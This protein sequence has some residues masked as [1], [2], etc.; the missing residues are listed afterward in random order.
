MNNIYMMGYIQFADG[1]NPWVYFNDK[2]LYQWIPR[3][4]LVADP[5]ET[6]SFTAY[7]RPKRLKGYE[8]MKNAIR[9]LAIEWQGAFDERR[10]AYGDLATWRGFFTRYGT[11]YGLMR[12]FHENGIC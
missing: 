1:S 4:E 6:D 11:R 2:G 3:F 8:Q 7:E 10:Y 12:E 5:G 9:N